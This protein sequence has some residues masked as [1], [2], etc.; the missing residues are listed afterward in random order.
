MKITHTFFNSCYN[1]FTKSCS[2]VILDIVSF[3]FVILFICLFF[4]FCRHLHLKNAFRFE[5]DFDYGI[6]ERNYH[7]HTVFGLSF[8]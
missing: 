8:C 2:Y 5:I 7:I 3:D 1:L 4:L 6:D